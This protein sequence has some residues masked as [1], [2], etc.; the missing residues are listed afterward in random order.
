MV[1]A[2]TF[3]TYLKNREKTFGEF[4]IEQLKLQLRKIKEESISN[5][6]NLK[7]KT[8]RNLKEKGI[9]VFEVRNS[10]EAKKVLFKIIGKDEVVVKAKSNTINE[11]GLDLFKGR[12][13][14]VETD[15]GDF[16]V[17][18]CD[19]EAIHP[20]LPALHIPIEKIVKKINEKFKVRLEKSPE[21]ITEWISE[22]LKKEILKADVGLTGANVIS[23][24]GAIF[25]LENEGNISLISRIPKKHV[26]IAGIDKIVSS[27]QDAITICQASTIWGTGTSLPAYINVISSPSKTA[28]IA[29]KEIFGLHGAK[30]VYLILLDNGRSEAIK[31][32]FGELLYCI[33]C[34]ACLYF[35]P[36]YRQIFEKYG[37]NYFGGRGVGITTFINGI[38]VAFDR[39]L[40]FCTTC[41]ACKE[42]CPLDIDIP[43][44]MRKLRKEAVEKGLETEANKRMIENIAVDGN[45]FGKIEEGKIPKELYCC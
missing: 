3:K 7:E 20:V 13:R 38:E 4:N 11:I 44:L 42:N 21:K 16:I 1:V 2:L 32:G 41:R 24:E 27:T 22:H 8:I 10:E 34:G 12:N 5:L 6:E 43:E 29:G 26:I 15:C 19:E 35:C 45:P 25:I 18:F 39:G 28:D 17:Q 33:N 36:I 23:A 40:Y 31:N 14:V 30:E 9:K 37:L